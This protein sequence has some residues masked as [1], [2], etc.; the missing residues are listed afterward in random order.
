MQ[1]YYHTPKKSKAQTSI[2]FVF[3]V[4][5]AASL[6]IIFTITTHGQM[7]KLQDEK[8]YIL[9]QDL[10]FKVQNEF[11]LAS[12]VED[13]YVRQFEIPDK[14]DSTLIYNITLLENN[15]VVS[16]STEHDHIIAFIPYVFGNITKGENRIQKAD[17]GL[18]LNTIV[19]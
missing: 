2:E 8:E 16:A 9:L 19:T 11:A 14:L 17:G 5:L 6:V 15:T 7:K 1:S 10:V 13:G 3:L 12:R 4:G 18:Y